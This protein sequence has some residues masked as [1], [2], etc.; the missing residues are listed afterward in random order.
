MKPKRLAAGIVLAVLA[1]TL[2]VVSLYRSFDQP[3]GI[4]QVEAQRRFDEAMKRM[5]E[6]VKNRPPDDA[7]KKPA[8]K[9]GKASSHTNR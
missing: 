4:P 7:V 3:Q 1:C 6:D 5:A 2:A 8:A 9:S